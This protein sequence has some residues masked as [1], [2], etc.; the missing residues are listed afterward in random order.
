[1]KIL[2]GYDGTEAAGEAIKVAKKHARAFAAKVHVV[3]S[4]VSGTEHQQQDIDNAES[5]LQ[6]AASV[7]RKADIPCEAHLLIRG[8]E[9]G[10]DLVRFATENNIDEIVVGV[11]KRS[12][13]EKILLGSTAQYVI[14]KAP[15]TVVTV[16]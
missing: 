6:W 5:Q 9:P 11:K 2:V 10:E 8:F 1:M 15:C 16:K 4:M 7:F 14:I 13:V 3:F 12:R